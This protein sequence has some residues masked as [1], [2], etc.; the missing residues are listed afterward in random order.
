MWFLQSTPNKFNKAKNGN[1][2]LQFRLGNSSSKP[3]YLRFLVR[4]SCGPTICDQKAC[5]GHVKDVVWDFLAYHLP[6]GGADREQSGNLTLSFA[7]DATSSCISTFGC[8]KMEYGICPHLRHTIVD[9]TPAWYSDWVIWSSSY[10]P[11]MRVHGIS[12]F[13]SIK[14]MTKKLMPPVNLGLP[15]ISRQNHWILGVKAPESGSL[16]AM[17]LKSDMLIHVCIY[18]YTYP[19]V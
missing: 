16:F 17:C 15:C 14:M 3:I 2:E 5:F 6:P 13:A 11:Y 10:W 12:P 8:L 1:T 7:A 19:I 18:I 9:G 4:M